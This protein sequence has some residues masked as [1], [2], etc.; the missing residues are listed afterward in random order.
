MEIIYLT[1]LYHWNPYNLTDCD[2]EGCE[3]QVTAG[4]RNGGLTPDTAYNGFG[5]KHFFKT[6]KE[7]FTGSQA[8]TTTADTTQG[9]VGVLDQ[10]GVVREVVASGTRIMLPKI[11]SAGYIRTR[12]PISPL[13][14]DGNTIFKELAALKDIVM[15]M[16]TYSHMF[17]EQAP[18]VTTFKTAEATRQTPGP[19]VH[20]VKIPSDEVTNL[21]TNEGTIYTA[22]TSVSKAHVHKL[23]I[24]YDSSA[25]QPWVIQEC[26]D[27]NSKC[28]DDHPLYIIQDWDQDTFSK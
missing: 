8:D 26:D 1:P 25:A 2:V 20:V 24:R 22:H 10:A 5:N 12:Y 11:G 13:H 3:D 21:M 28:W 7:L 19:H 16:N 9:S 15:R 6:P 27:N 14:Y 23:L 18:A 17:R 4:G